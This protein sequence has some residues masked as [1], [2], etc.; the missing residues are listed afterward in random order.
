MCPPAAR[1]CNTSYLELRGAAFIANQQ[2]VALTIHHD[3]LL[4]SAT[5]GRERSGEKG[6]A[7]GGVLRQQ[8]GKGRDGG[9]LWGRGGGEG[10]GPEHR[11][12]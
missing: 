6:R 9:C 5:W 12:S 11:R 10:E 1:R 8:G 2:Q 7:R 3:L 4:K